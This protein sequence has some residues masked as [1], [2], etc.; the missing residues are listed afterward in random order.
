[1]TPPSPPPTTKTLLGS[2]WAAKGMWAIISWYLLRQSCT[3][4]VD[5]WC[6]HSREL[7]SLSALNNTVKDKDM[8]VSLR[9]ED[10]DV[11]FMSAQVIVACPRL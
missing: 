8:T 11:L 4:V 7:V 2:G 5:I 6:V 9:R 1:M 3:Y 10:Q